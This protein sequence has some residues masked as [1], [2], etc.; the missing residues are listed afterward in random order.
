MNLPKITQKPY[1]TKRGADRHY[2]A[3]LN[4]YKVAWSGGGSFGWDWPTLRAN[5][6]EGYVYLRGICDVYDQLPE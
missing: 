3:V 2:E 4:A 1:R 6:P 5:W